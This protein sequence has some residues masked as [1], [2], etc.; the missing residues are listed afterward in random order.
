MEVLHIFKAIYPDSIGGIEKVVKVLSESLHAEHGTKST[1]LGVSKTVLETEKTEL[2]DGDIKII[3]IPEWFSL[4][5][6]PVPKFGP[7]VKEYKDALKS[8][9][10]VHYHFPW[11]IGDLVDRLY[12]RKNKK[13]TVVTYQSDVVKQRYMIV[14][15]RP[16]K[17]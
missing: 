9:D 7:F 6:M 2:Y 5:S 8:A 17:K 3:K 11:P 15:Y 12:N 13:T 1:I 14:L 10:I 16:L 4:G